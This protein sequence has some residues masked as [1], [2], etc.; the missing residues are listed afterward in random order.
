MTIREINNTGLRPKRSETLPTVGPQRNC[1]TENVAARA[2]PQVAAVLKSVPPRS[3][4]K[5]G[6]TGMI[7]PI[8]MESSM[9]VMNRN[10]TGSFC[11]T[12]KTIAAAAGR[13]S[14]DSIRLEIS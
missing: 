11:F 1:I 7:N 10:M 13:S 3:I 4:S 5:S 8:P 14:Q 2:P 12:V 6:I 9:T